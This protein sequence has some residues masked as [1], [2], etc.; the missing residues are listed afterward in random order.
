MFDVAR[1]VL[2]TT[3]SISTD[4]SYEDLMAFIKPFFIEISWTMINRRFFT[5]R[6][7]IMG[8]G[9]TTTQ[10][11]DL[12]VVLEGLDVPVTLSKHNSNKWSFE[13]DVYVHGFMEGQ[14]MGLFEP[15]EFSLI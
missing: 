13:G 9:P 4:P 1:G 10:E 8:I 15:Q 5:S 14:A 3:A 6:N 11:G 2:P 7:G 12:I